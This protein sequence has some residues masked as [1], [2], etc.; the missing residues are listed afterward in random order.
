MNLWQ[1]IPL[2]VRA[3]VIGFAVSTVGVGVWVAVISTVPAPWSIGLMAI[4]LW[5]YWKYFGG[6][7]WP[8]STASYRRESRRQPVQRIDPVERRCHE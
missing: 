7:G 1:R 5:A 2:V 3:V 8:T 6:T 4:L